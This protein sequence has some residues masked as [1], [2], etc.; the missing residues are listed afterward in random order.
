MPSNA[1][2]TDHRQLKVYLTIAEHH[3]LKQLA[4]REGLTITDYVKRALF[5]PTTP[6]LLEAL[7]A[8]RDHPSPFRSSATSALH[9]RAIAAK[10]IAKAH[11]ETA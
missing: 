3:A 2:L 5:T 4:G 10:T 6:D 11:G 7:I 9:M 8:I 1:W